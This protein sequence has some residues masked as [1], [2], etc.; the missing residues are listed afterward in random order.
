MS[1]AIT[2]ANGNV[3]PSANG[4]TNQITPKIAAG[5]HSKAVAIIKSQSFLEKAAKLPPKITA[6]AKN[7]VSGIYQKAEKKYGSGWAKFITGVAIVMA[8]TP[9]TLLSTA[10]AVGLAHAYT[11][12]IGTRPVQKMSENTMTR[13]QVKAAAQEMLKSIMDG[14]K[15]L[16]ETSAAD[17]QTPEPVRF[18]E[19]DPGNPFIPLAGGAFRFNGLTGNIEG[20]LNRTSPSYGT[21]NGC[22]RNSR[23]YTARRLFRAGDVRAIMRM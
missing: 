11:G 20:I 2:V 9:F 5:V 17:Y 7:L 12:L 21:I 19:R 13:E 1:K 10:A 8:P 22:H 14:L 6:A 3:K 18:A 23:E 16:A 15:G 4:T